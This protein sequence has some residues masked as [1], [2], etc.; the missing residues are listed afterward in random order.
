MPPLPPFEYDADTIGIW[1]LDDTAAS[2]TVTDTTETY[3]LTTTAGSPQFTQGP[4]TDMMARY[5][6]GNSAVGRAAPDPAM[7]AVLLGTWTFEAWVYCQT[8]A[9]QFVFA[10]YGGTTLET[11]AENAIARLDITAAGK[12]QIFYESGA[13]TNHTITQVAGGSVATQVWTHVAWVCEAGANRTMKFYIN[14]VLQDT[15]SDVLADGGTNARLMFGRGGYDSTNYLNGSLAQAQ[16]SNVARDAT[17]LLASYT[18][19]GPVQDANTVALWVMQESPPVRDVSS[20]GHHMTALLTVPSNIQSVARG[21]ETSKWFNS[22]DLVFRGCSL[23]DPGLQAL[24]LASWT[25]DYWVQPTR[26]VSQTIV[27]L[28][29]WG[30]TGDSVPAENI[31]FQTQYLTSTRTAQVFWEYDSGV[32]V[33]LTSDALFATDVEQYSAP[34]LLSITRSIDA[35]TITVQFLVNGVLKSTKT[36]VLPPNGGSA[37]NLR[38]GL[39]NA[40]LGPMRLSDKVR[41]EAELLASYELARI[42]PMSDGGQANYHKRA[43][44]TESAAYVEWDTTSPTGAY[45]GGGTL[46]PPLG[47]ILYQWT[48]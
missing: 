9:M 40:A 23:K 44:R 1:M 48:T 27:L 43:W 16:L 12:L 29:M 5:F 13:G 34:F 47:V 39:G 7:L 41:S 19:H 4:T 20:N 8:A 42:D 45:P 15:L 14:G 24:A 18:D 36:S 22:V 21:L 3:P 26:G 46:D 25:T 10:Y 11:A 6:P 32:N 28:T 30:P 35:G 38:W 2:T 17:Y 31:L 37:T 33:T